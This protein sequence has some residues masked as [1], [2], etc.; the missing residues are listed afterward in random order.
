MCFKRLFWEERKKR[1]TLNRESSERDPVQSGRAV[2]ANC[3]ESFDALTAQMVISF[4]FA[5][6]EREGVPLYTVHDCFVTS[7]LFANVLPSL[8][9]DSLLKLGSPIECINSYVKRNFFP[10]EVNFDLKNKI[11]QKQ[12]EHYIV[13][14]FYTD[15]KKMT[16]VEKAKASFITDYTEF[17]SDLTPEKKHTVL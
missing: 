8:Y 11:T 3:I 2:T 13:I 14:P 6:S 16:K 10:N 7:A 9:I 1:L 15:E 5:D 4:F 17:L 12:L